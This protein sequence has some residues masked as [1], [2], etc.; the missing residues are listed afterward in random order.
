[1]R[2]VN[3]EEIRAKEVECRRNGSCKGPEVGRNSSVRRTTGSK[4]KEVRESTPRRGGV[5][6]ALDG[7]K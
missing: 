7:V 6:E 3:P 5:Q 2:D 4:L 1:M